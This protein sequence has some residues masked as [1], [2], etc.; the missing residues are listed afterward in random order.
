MRKH[1]R[2]AWSIHA[3]RSDIQTREELDQ[4]EKDFIKFLRSQDPEFGYNICRGGEGFTGPH[5][6]ET[7][8]KSGEASDKRWAQPGFREATV[9]KI[10]DNYL[11]R[12][13]TGGKI[14]FRWEDGHTL[15]D[16]G[17]GNLSASRKEN[18]HNPEYRT[19]ISAALGKRYEDDPGLA[20]RI[21]A[22]LTGHEVTQET[23]RRISASK[24]GRPWTE[25]RRLAQAKKGLGKPVLGE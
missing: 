15:S 18:W 25:A 2:D 13:E 22:S 7:R 11:F 6:E 23:R 20:G 21:S 10:R 8:K 14:G 19:M 4:T 3:L 24:V 1:P 5:S 16:E 9:V 17:R 12:K